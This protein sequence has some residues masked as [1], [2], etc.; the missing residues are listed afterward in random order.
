[1]G[2]FMGTLRGLH[3]ESEKVSKSLWILGVSLD[4][5]VRAAM[6]LGSCAHTSGV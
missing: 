4:Q 1:M 6:R 3:G 5:A 2:S